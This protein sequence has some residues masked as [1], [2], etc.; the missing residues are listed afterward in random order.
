M[1]AILLQAGYCF[2]AAFVLVV[3]VSTALHVMPRGKQVLMYC[4]GG[5]RC[6]KASA[7]V[8]IHNWHT[9]WQ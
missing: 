5:I 8:N 4:T 2:D 7:Y 3:Y 6:E 9:P 1:R